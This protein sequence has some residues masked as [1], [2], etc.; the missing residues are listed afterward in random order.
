M[1]ENVRQDRLQLVGLR[2]LDAARPL[3]AGA[4]LAEQGSI[5]YVTSA[6]RSPTLGRRSVSA[7]EARRARMGERLRV[8]DNGVESAAEVLSP[9]QL[10]SAGT[11]TP[12]LT[13]PPRKDLFWRCA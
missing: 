12:W 6:C 2:A 3:V 10:R 8:F 11:R 4:H 7:S 5:G 1:P 13:R 9:M